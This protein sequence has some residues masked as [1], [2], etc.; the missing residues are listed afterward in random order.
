MATL[1]LSA[2]QADTLRELREALESTTNA[3]V[4]CAMFAPDSARKRDLGNLVHEMHE[5]ERALQEFWEING[6][7]N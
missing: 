2:G 6:L 4:G 7:Y 1:T 3:V 5:A